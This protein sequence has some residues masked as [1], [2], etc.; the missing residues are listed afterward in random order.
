MTKSTLFTG[1]PIFSQTISLIPKSLVAKLAKNF[2]TDKS[3]KR[4]NTFDHLVTMLFAVMNKCNSLR[5]VITGMQASTS[6]L[7][8]LGLKSTPRRSTFA[9][10]NERRNHEFFGALYLALYEHHYGRLPDS[11]KKLALEE[12]LF[13]IDSSIITLFTDALKS[14]GSYDANGKKKG[15]LKLHALLKASDNLPCFVELSEGK[16]S[17]MQLLHKLKLPKGSILAMDKAYRSYKEFKRFTEEGVTWVTRRHERAVYT[18][19]GPRP[20]SAQQSDKGVQEDYTIELGNPKTASTNPVQKARLVKF[21]DKDLNT[22][23]EFITN[24]FKYGSDTIADIYKKRW[25]IETFFK[26]IKQN[27]Q[28]HFFLGDSENAIR[29]QLWCTLIADLLIKV[30]KHKVAK[31]RKWSMSNLTSLIRIHLFTYIS[32]KMFLRY[33]EKALLQN[34]KAKQSTTLKLFD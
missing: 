7:Y 26:R 13:V 18:I 20:V 16:A 6:K 23:F 14:T 33:P 19:V 5:E 8:H 22:T 4:F 27:F 3:T 1:Q 32:L 17:D 25:L 34:L 9:D 10:A 29:I 30:V 2:R 31:Y 28:L 21:Y 15:G 12:K 11:W 24:N